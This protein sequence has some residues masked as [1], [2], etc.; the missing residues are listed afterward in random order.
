[1]GDTRLQGF[2]ITSEELTGSPLAPNLLPILMHARLFG[3]PVSL[4]V[5]LLITYNFSWNL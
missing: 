5:I 2:R 1:M 3:I 4:S